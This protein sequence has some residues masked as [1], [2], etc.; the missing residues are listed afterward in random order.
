MSPRHT[1]W[2]GVRRASRRQWRART[3][4][5]LK[6]PALRE[7]DLSYNQLEALPLLEC[8]PKLE[9]LLLDHNLIKGPLTEVKNSS[10][11]KKLDL[12]YNQFMYSAVELNAE[13]ENLTK[14][15]H[16]AL[17][18]KDNPFCATIPSY[19]ILCLQMLPLLR[20]LDDISVHD[21]DAQREAAQRVQ[22]SLRAMDDLASRHE[23]RQD[24]KHQLRV[25][26]PSADKLQRRITRVEV[27]LDH[28]RLQEDEQTLGHA[29]LLPDSVVH[30]LFTM[31]AVV[32]SSQEASG[33]QPLELQVVSIPETW[34]GAE[35]FA[36]CSSITQVK[37]PESLAHI[38]ESA[39]AGC[40][41]LRSVA[42]PSWVAIG[43]GAFK[44]SL[45]LDSVLTLDTEAFC[46]CRS[47][48][49]VNIPGSL[50][51]ISPRAFSGCSALLKLSIPDSIREIGES[52][53]FAC[54]SLTTLNIPES[55]LDQ[56]TWTK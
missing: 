11:L 33:K 45:S 20:K 37:L 30:V 55:W 49:E 4:F 32:C 44:S 52:A 16:L 22:L 41:S 15:T 43:E 25:L 31:N 51:E 21:M 26:Q 38:G 35:A 27:L 42:I 9:V 10:T 24:L 6:L 54:S 56:R 14:F 1:A 36:N 8:L 28:E 17:K 3:S 46:G 7:L 50:Q 53:F 39:F 40:A 12:S 18:L 23:A 13:L 29:G 5:S 2:F 47:L 34:I 19:Q 48:K